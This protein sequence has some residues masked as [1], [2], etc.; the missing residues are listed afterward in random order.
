[1][2]LSGTRLATATAL[3]A[4]A[5]AWAAPVEAQLAARSPGGANA[6][7]AP[8]APA[9]LVEARNAGA[10]VSRPAFLPEVRQDWSVRPAAVNRPAIHTGFELPD[11]SAELRYRASGM[12]APVTL[13]RQLPLAFGVDDVLDSFSDRRALQQVFPGLKS[14]SRVFRLGGSIRF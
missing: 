11:L 8:V 13:A 10:T 14:A 12:P 4:A 3:L 6:L 1:M 5:A 9:L 2:R 7:Q